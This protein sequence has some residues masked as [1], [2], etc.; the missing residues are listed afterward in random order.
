MWSGKWSPVNW[1][2]IMSI[3]NKQHR[4]KTRALD[5]T[6]IYSKSIVGD[7]LKSEPQGS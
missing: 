7:S 5:N 6:E 2:Q 4:P 1:M 3:N